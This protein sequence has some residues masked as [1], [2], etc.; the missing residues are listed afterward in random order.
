MQFTKRMEL[1]VE[2]ASKI[3]ESKQVMIS[4]DYKAIDLLSDVYKKISDLETE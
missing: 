1:A 3:L 4:S 2:Y